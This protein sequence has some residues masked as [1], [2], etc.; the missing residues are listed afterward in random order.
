MNG[1]RFRLDFAYPDQKIA[2]E[3]DGWEWHSSRSAFDRDRRRDRM[4]QLAGWTVLRITSQTSD[5][6]LLDTLRALVRKGP[7]E[8]PKRTNGG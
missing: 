2:I 4:L 6:D 7:A 3:Y 5:S 1:E 8:G